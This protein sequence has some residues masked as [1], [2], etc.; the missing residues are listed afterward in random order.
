VLADSLKSLRLPLGS[1][2]A[3]IVLLYPSLA[4]R[5]S[6]RG[7]QIFPLQVVHLLHNPYDTMIALARSTTAVNAD[8]RLFSIN[9][10]RK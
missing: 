4:L 5:N 7:I 2:P 10:V 1:I 9:G 8:S 3:S 6:L